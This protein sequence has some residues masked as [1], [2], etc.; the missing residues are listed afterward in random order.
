MKNA[1]A[2]S[3]GITAPPITAATRCEYWPASMIPWLRPNN[4]YA[5]QEGLYYTL[6]MSSRPKVSVRKRRMSA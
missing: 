2:M 1:F 6:M 5:S 4:A 3:V